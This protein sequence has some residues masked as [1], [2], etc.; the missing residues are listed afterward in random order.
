MSD[1]IPTVSDMA[2][3]TAPAPASRAGS[4]LRAVPDA[5]R[6]GVAD[7]AAP[8]VVPLAD[9]RAAME[10]AVTALTDLR[11]VVHQ[12]G[13]A[14]LAELVALADEL[15]ARATA[16]RFTLTAE[17]VS[18]GEVAASDAPSVAGWVRTHASSTR[19]GG[20]GSIARAVDT[21]ALRSN[22]LLRDAVESGRLALAVAST[23]VTELGR[24][25]SRLVPGARETVLAA[26]IEMGVEHGSSGV[27]LV[28][29]ELLARYGVQDE[30]ER[31]HDRLRRGRALSRPIVDDG[32]HEYRLVLDP[33]GAAVLEAA[34]EALSAPAPTE[35]PATGVRQADL[36]SSD[37][38]RADA[39][40]EIVRSGVSSMDTRAGRGA[41]ATL[42]V[43][44]SHDDLRARTYAARTI[45][46]LDAGTLLPPET[47]RR[48][49]CDADVVPA[50]LG[51]DGEI[52][53]LGRAV[54]LFTPP[55]TR[56]LW[57]RDGGCT[58]PGCT[59]PARWTDA[60]HLLHWV[61][62]GR[63]D[64]D[65]AALLCGRHHT[66]V[67]SRRLHGRLVR[68]GG[69]EGDPERGEHP[70]CTTPSARGTPPGGPPRVVWDLVPGSYDRAVDRLA[71]AG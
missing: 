29:P 1:L 11:T 67:H 30:L 18:R 71:R 4:P 14:E 63:T 37:Q 50:V 21:L 25:E 62:G 64:L 27:R 36:R 55:Q 69:P 2:T 16:A 10:A 6:A 60:H 65:N 35:D 39:L 58:Y 26:M 20:C 57:L 32:L 41:K 54:R 17:A 12:A 56:A 43:T 46:G 42:L 15:A 8:V 31:D 38:R 7:G 3:P 47:I 23:I 51:Q 19:Q 33:E 24:I 52:L 61:D 68:V 70:A 49:A 40:V 28:R 13:G 53:D 9:R 45:G 59:T 22:A 44:M 66:V 48:A 5:Q 34:V